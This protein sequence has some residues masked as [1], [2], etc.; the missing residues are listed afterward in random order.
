MAQSNVQSK[1]LLA[2]ESNESWKFR[3]MP[4]MVPSMDNAKELSWE[5][6]HIYHV[7]TFVGLI[8]YPPIRDYVIYGRPLKTSVYNQ[9]EFT[10]LL[11]SLGANNIPIHASI[12]RRTPGGGFLFQKN[13]K[14]CSEPP[15]LQAEKPQNQ[16]KKSQHGPG[17]APE[18]PCCPLLGQAHSAN[19]CGC[20]VYHPVWEQVSNIANIH[21]C[22]IWKPSY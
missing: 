13:T 11:H 3:Y 2:V 12:L 9:P 5:V 19:T 20:C 6:I 1:Q 7:I 4:Q 18:Q 15:C 8:P 21:S 10:N 22:K 17:T 16:E 14:I